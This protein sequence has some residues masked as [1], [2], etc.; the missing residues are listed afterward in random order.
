MKHKIEKEQKGTS[1]VALDLTTATLSTC[2]HFIL[3]ECHSVQYQEGECHGIEVK[4]CF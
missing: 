2:M 4:T 3:N 1:V